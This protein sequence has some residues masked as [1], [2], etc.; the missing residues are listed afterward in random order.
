MKPLLQILML[1]FLT[2]F[3]CSHPTQMAGGGDEVTTGFLYYQNGKAAA[4]STVIAV[5][6]HV[7]PGLGNPIT[8][9]ETITDSLGRYSFGSLPADIYN[10]YG[11]NDSLASFQAGVEI[12]NSGRKTIRNDTLKPTGS[13]IGTVRLSASLD[14]RTVIIMVIGS[15]MV[16][17]PDDS[18]GHFSL[19]G[20]AEGTYP[21]RFLAVGPQYPVL[22]TS[23]SVK[24]GET[25]DIGEITLNSYAALDSIVRTNGML[26]ARGPD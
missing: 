18:S 19:N 15:T 22:D 17:G 25:T 9:F 26:K 12:N 2:A 24:S 10:I 4:N 14:S 7:V 6:S 20:L 23:F 1:A 13:I 11:T 3:E 5:S 8:Q 16:T 21:V